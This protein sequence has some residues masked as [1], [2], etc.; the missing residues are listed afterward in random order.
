MRQTRRRVLIAGA[1]AAGLGTFGTASAAEEWSTTYDDGL[2]E[3]ADA[4]APLDDGYLIAGRSIADETDHYWWLDVGPDGEK[5]A[6]G[7]FEREEDGWIDDVAV[8]DDGGFL[9]VGTDSTIASMSSWAHRVGPDGE[10]QWTYDS[11]DDPLM[12]AS[13]VATGDGELVLAGRNDSTTEMSAIARGLAADGTV[14]WA[15]EFEEESTLRA[16][17]RRPDGGALLGGSLGE[18][19]ERAAWLVAVDG[20]GAVDWRRTYEDVSLENSPGGVFDLHAEDGAVAMAVSLGAAAGLVGTDADGAPTWT[21]SVE[22]NQARPTVAR[23][24]DGYALGGSYVL[25]DSAYDYFLANVNPDA[26]VRWA[27]RYDGNHLGDLVGA[28]SQVLFAGSDR[29]DAVVQALATDAA[30]PGGDEMETGSD[31]AGDETGTTDDADGEERGG[32][33][34]AD[35]EDDGLPGFGTGAALAGLA[36]AGL[37]RRRPD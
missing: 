1:A 16:A 19:R 20:D 30:P 22:S 35:R 2:D 26:G 8:A 27:S 29:S 23:I 4:A 17:A 6:S 5:R 10:A 15:R 32:D 14:A 3:Y 7:T 21:A 24:D 31:T 18:L 34:P 13:A 25:A 9:I 28:G 11:A 12:A 33:G 36:G 37:W